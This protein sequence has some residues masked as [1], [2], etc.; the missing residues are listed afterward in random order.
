MSDDPLSTPALANGTA[1]SPLPPPTSPSTLLRF[2]IPKGRMK[3]NVLKL[4]SDAGID[5]AIS[6]RGYRPTISLPSYDIKLLKPQ[7]I[8][9][10]LHAGS[11]DVGFGGADWVEELKAHNLVDL[12]DT[13]LDPVRVVAAGPSHEMLE[14]AIAQNKHV[15]IASEYEGL[16]RDWIK[17]KGLNATFVR[18]YGATESF[19]P[20]DA[21]LIVDNTATGSTLRANN[22]VILDTVFTSST[23]L[24]ANGDALK[25]ASKK[26]M[27][28]D[29]VV[30]LSSVLLARQKVMVLFNIT[31]SVMRGG[32]IEQLPCMR[33]PTVT[34]LQGGAGY[35]V[36]VCVAREECVR[37]LPKLKEAGAMDIIVTKVDQI[38][39]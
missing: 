19:P 26:K 9:E 35:A 30:L 27:I 28:D 22:L 29:L 6:D 39:V 2:A 37:L 32:L 23:R 12:L 36:S 7:N 15:T 13:K 24:Y 3:D 1:S 18:A 33:A 25:D 14:D 5:I 38:V 16:T 10:M 8:I 17:R 31:E 21:D 34:S 4:L 20:E 11:R